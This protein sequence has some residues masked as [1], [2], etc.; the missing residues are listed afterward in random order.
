[1]RLA[2]SIVW[3]C[4]LAVTAGV[5]CGRLRQKSVPDGASGD[6]AAHGP[7]VDATAEAA[8]PL[9]DAT[10]E[11][12][13]PVVDAGVAPDGRASRDA[14]PA[15]VP[16]RMLTNLEYDLT[17]HDLLGVA[18]QAR[19]TFQSDQSDGDFAGIGATFTTNDARFE[20]DEDAAESL[21][22]AA[23]ADDTLRAR[24]V[25]CEPAA[26]G[27]A[28]CA[29]QIITAFGQRAWRRPL[30]SDEIDALATLAA[31]P[32]AG[33]TFEESM[34]TVVAAMIA[35]A[36]FLMRLEIDPDP[37][38]TTPHPL[39]TWEL[40]SRLSY[41]LWSSMPDDRLFALAADGTLAQDAVIS[42]EIVR[43]IADPR[44][45]GFVEGFAMQW[46]HEQDLDLFQDL[47]NASWDASL[48]AAM[49]Q[50]LRLYL[51]EFLRNP[52][53]FSTFVDADVNFVNAPL[54]RLYGMDAT[55]LGDDLVR[56][57][58]TTDHRVGL[59]GLGAFLTMTSQST[60]SSPTARGQWIQ[61][62]LLCAPRQETPFDTPDVI[63][64][65]L[66]TPGRQLVDSIEAEPGCASCHVAT[67]EP[68]VALEEFD[69][70]GAYRTHYADGTPVDAHGAL[71]DGTPVDGELALARGLATDGAL[72]PC[73]ARELL[74]YALGRDLGDADK[75]IVDDVVGA[76]TT[77]QPT[78]ARL[79]AAVVANDAFRTRRGEAAQ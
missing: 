53:D 34:Q 55:G 8:A 35:S 68:G 19:A 22:A 74:S 67:D 52:L 33:A 12:A 1:V 78:I 79:L 24:I 14:D 4:A 6:D 76:W 77:A 70:I 50:E 7:V 49:A 2:S 51:G 28:T 71:P 5:G 20:Q 62:R 25:T 27:D 26:P 72:L 10:A 58:D 44:A 42:G 36:P 29:R 31:N 66:T 30:T 54:A 11:A 47:A 48:R 13:A 17:I 45:D 23:F 69:Q 61:L 41:L 40:A 39:T 64:N 15:L 46:L 37:T 59:L 21:A 57:V 75:P 60:R 73:V 65:T 56:V 43:M 32:N 3:T 16:L 63:S 18:G 9:V 38:S